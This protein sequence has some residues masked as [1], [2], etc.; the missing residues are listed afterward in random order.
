MKRFI[1]RA[2]LGERG[3]AV[4][5]LL[6]AVT[7]LFSYAFRFGYVFVDVTLFKGFSMALFIIMVLNAVLLTVLLALRLKN[8]DITANKTF[9]T[10]SCVSEVLG[11]IFAVVVLVNFIVSGS[12]SI[13]VG[14]RLCRELFPVWLT[15]V[16]VVFL[17]FIAPNMKSDFFKKLLSAF[18]T[19][20]L[21]VAVIGRIF[22]L[23]PFKFTSGPVVFDNG[24]GYS[25]VFATSDKGTAYLEYEKDGKTTRVYD[26]NNGRKNGDSIIHTVRVPYEELSGSAYKVSSTRVIDELSYGGRT[27]KTIESKIYRFNDNFGENINVLTVS[28]WHTENEKVVKAASH[29]DDYSAVILLGDGSPGLMFPEEVAD[30]IISLGSDLTDGSMPVIFA[31]GN[32]E[33]R[34]REAAKLSRYL[35]MDKFYFTAKIGD[36]NFVVLDSGE[37]KEDSHPEYGSM[38]NYEQY[39]RDM[40]EWLE[41]L[42]NNDNGKNIALVHAEDVC[43]EK[44]L[45][46]RALKKL[47]DMNVSLLVSGHE[48]ISEFKKNDY[49]HVLVDGGVGANGK[50]SMVVSMLRLTPEK[51]DVISVDENGSKVIDEDVYW[52]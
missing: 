36:Y 41:N 18:I 51:T 39:R 2:F 7:V 29:L 34:G 43:I 4:F 26:E 17:I 16:G 1:N 20:V 13:P 5:S 52:K 23:T 38:V 35:G 14:L 12:E 9:C 8:P 15:A 47:N 30:Y 6:A 33:T 19:V 22:P 48:H 11:I 31:R 27:G 50:G 21:V 44:D 32:H 42:E 3:A 28:D 46:D 25:V 40:V 24:E 37:D 10:V 45:S 49:F